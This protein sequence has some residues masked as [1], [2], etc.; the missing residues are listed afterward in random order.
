MEHESVL[1]ASGLVGTPLYK[2]LSN[3]DLGKVHGFRVTM[4]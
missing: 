1:D 3:V 4:I 2:E